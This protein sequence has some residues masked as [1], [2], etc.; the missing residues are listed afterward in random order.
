MRAKVQ[1][2]IL[3]LWYSRF[4]LT[5]LRYMTSCAAQ[6]HGKGSRP[7]LWLWLGPY[8]QRKVNLGI[9]YGVIIR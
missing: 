6:G 1:T 3:G 8:G 5:S 4:P 2:L 9:G 7:W